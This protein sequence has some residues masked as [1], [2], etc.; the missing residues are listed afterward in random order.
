MRNLHNQSA[1]ENTEYRLFCTRHGKSV[2]TAMGDAGAVSNHVLQDGH[3]IGDAAISRELSRTVAIRQETGALV[4]SYK[5]F[6]ENY[7]PRQKG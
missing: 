2:G 3:E 6:R 7:R 1:G 5:Y 4:V